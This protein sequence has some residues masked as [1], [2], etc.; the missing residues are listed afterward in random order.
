MYFFDYSVNI[1]VEDRRLKLQNHSLLY[2]T[3]QL[4]TAIGMVATSPHQIGRRKSAISPRR[5]NT[6]QK[7]FFSTK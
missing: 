4:T 5:I 1:T 3:H 6:I 2:A 7:I